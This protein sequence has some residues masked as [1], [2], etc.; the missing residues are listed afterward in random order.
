MFIFLHVY[1]VTMYT[2]IQ[3]TKISICTETVHCSDSIK[4]HVMIW[5]L[6]DETGEVRVSNNRGTLYSVT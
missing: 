4:Q 1:N 6:A 2:Y 5:K 3:N